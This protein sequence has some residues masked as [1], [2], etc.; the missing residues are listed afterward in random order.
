MLRSC[1]TSPLI[2]VTKLYTLHYYQYANGYVFPGERHDFWEMVYVDQ[3]ETD[4]GA[5]CGVHHLHQGQAI[6]HQPN[7]FHAIWSRNPK[8]T[9]LFIISFSC[10]GEAM[11]AFQGRI[12]TLDRAQRRLIGKLVKEGKRTFGAVLDAPCYDRM[13]PVADAPIGGV[14]ML[15]LL[16][17]Q[18]LINLLR[19]P[20]CLEPLELHPAL[21]DDKEAIGTVEQVIALMRCNLVAQLSFLELCR[22]TGVSSTVLKQRFK[23]VTGMS[24][25][26]YY[27]LLRLDE[28]RRILRQGEMNITQVSI[29]LGYSSPQAFSRQFKRLIGVSPSQYLQMVKE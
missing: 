18:L 5:D 2:N 4:V 8:G 26:V 25:M 16:L 14:Q 7:E 9:N 20:D 12:C 1:Y 3:G 15:V 27:Q 28:S 19:N 13:M 29:E 17:T 10:E 23:H 22:E 24:V 21:T 11:T 6:F